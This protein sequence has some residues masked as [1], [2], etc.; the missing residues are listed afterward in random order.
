M[1]INVTY[2]SLRQ[3]LYICFCYIKPNDEG[4]VYDHIEPEIMKYSSKGNALLMGDFNS[5]T[6][7]GQDFIEIDCSDNLPLPDDHIVDSIPVRNNC[8]SKVTLQGRTLLH[9][10]ISSQIKMLNGRKIGDNSGFYML[11]TKRQQYC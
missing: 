9:L 2:L 3:D 4:A 11:Q 10:C 5:R 6:G 1:K 7:N 8:D